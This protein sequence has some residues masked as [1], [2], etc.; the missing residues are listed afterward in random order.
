MPL[1][2]RL[3]AIMG[4]APRSP[5]E[6]AVEPPPSGFIG[7]F[8]KTPPNFQ[9]LWLYGIRPGGDLL[10]Y[11]KDTNAS[12]WQGPKVVGKGW[13]SLKDVIPAGGNRLYGLTPDGKLL[14]YE[15]TGFNDGSFTWKPIAEV[16][17]GWTYSRIFS[18]GDGIIYAI[19]Q[20]GKLFWY[21]HLGFREGARSWLGPK[22]VGSGWNG[23][24]D[25]F[26]GGQGDVYAVRP[27]GTL[28]LSHEKDYENGSDQW[29]P[30]RTVGSG[31]NSFQ[32]IIPAGGGVILAIRPDGKLLWYR[33]Q[34]VSPKLGRAHDVWEG[35][36]QIGSGWQD[37][38]KVIVLIPETVL[39]VVR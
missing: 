6:P 10:W 32:Q 22:E 11:R 31:W 38:A 21:R 28:L 17:S 39:P 26:S 27:D 36:V 7:T 20:D 3:M 16:G 23:L 2:P 8:S 1:V 24:R 9:P 33:H 13:T 30:A 37:F 18:G 34:L 19:R 35:P 5:S 4:P 14:W 29:V 25:A 12:A 15:H